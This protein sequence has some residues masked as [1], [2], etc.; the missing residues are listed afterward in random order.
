MTWSYFKFFIEVTKNIVIS[1]PTFYV[2]EEGYYTAVFFKVFG[3]SLVWIDL[4][5]VLNIR[6]RSLIPGR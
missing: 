5:I 4:G 1:R 3:Q 2:L 6:R